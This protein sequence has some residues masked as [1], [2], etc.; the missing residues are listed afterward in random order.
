MAG[1]LDGIRVLDFTHALAGPFGSMILADLGA[2]V[3]QVSRIDERDDESRGPGPHIQHRSTYRFSADRGKR[4]IQLNLKHARG[5]ELALSLAERCDVLTENFTPGTL[6]RLGLGYDVVSQ[7]N[8]RIIYA[9]VAGHG[10]TGPYARRGAF[11]IVAQAMS[12]LMSITGEADGP[13]M[14]AGASLGDTIGGAYLAMGVISALYEREKSGAGQ[15]V[16]VA[17]VESMM[18]HLENAI[19]RYSVSGQPPGHVGAR[20]PLVTPFQSFQ[21]SDGWIVVAGVRDWEG[22]TVAIGREE[23]GRDPRYQSSQERNARHGELEPPLVEAFL[24]RTTAEWTELLE[25]IAIAAPLC[26]IAEAVADEQIAARGAVIEMMMPLEGAPP[27]KVLL[28][29][30][31]VR[32]SRTSPAV[33]RPASWVGEDTVPVLT[34]LLG[35]SE[36]EVAELEQEGVVRARGGSY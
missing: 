20:H 27:R 16:D 29:N 4:N 1:P 10:Q 24:Q 35:L 21:T 33:V 8:P 12:G 32:L 30:N 18:F 2:E 3:I 31:P 11:D 36:A 6:E 14:R 19:I 17:M 34:R 13:P 28:P 26:N 23:L 15:R 22:F 5:V 7:R 25:G 9:S